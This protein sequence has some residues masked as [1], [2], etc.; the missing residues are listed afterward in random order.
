MKARQLLALGALALVLS[1]GLLYWTQ[2]ERP[3][4]AE[5][6][7]LIF[8]DLA[9]RQESIDSIRLLGAGN[10]PLVTL[11]KRNGVW[12]VR[13]RG[14]WPADA[15]KISQ[16]LFQLSQTRLL[17][18]KTDDPA[19]YARIGV[20][21]VGGRSAQGMELRLDGGGKP[22][23]LLLGHSRGNPD[24]DYLRVGDGKLSWLSDR[25]LDISRDPVEWLDH[26]LVDRP[27]ARIAEVQIDSIDEGHFVLAPR[28]DRFRLTDLPSAAMGQSHAG[29]AMAGALDQLELDDVGDDDGKATIE[30]HVRFLGVDGADID[31]AAWR[32]QGKVWA[33][34]TATLDEARAN[35]WLAQS[36][37]TD[38]GQ[39]AAALQPVRTQVAAWQARFAG[40]RFAIPNFKAAVLLMSRGQILKGAE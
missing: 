8:P 14:G 10:A 4:E 18:A 26:H 24:G 3:I 9:Q 13:E 28:D 38:P 39:R 15:G 30:R 33:R 11:S 7:S 16:M 25:H 5:P 31:L 34:L 21:P 6:Q 2:R 36:G 35:A 17:E 20:E 40:K 23:R 19:L 32:M 37:K 1:A 12:R 22:M 27:L 29:D